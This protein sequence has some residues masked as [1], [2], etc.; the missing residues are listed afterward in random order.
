MSR[1]EVRERL[2]LISAWRTRI[3]PH[4]KP[5][6]SGRHPSAIPE[7]RIC[8]DGLRAIILQNI[9]PGSTQV[10]EHPDG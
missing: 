3:L 10:R 2:R 9:R 8:R 4:R 5:G 7:N 1:R 6:C